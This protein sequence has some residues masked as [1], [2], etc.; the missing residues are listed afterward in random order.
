MYLAYLD[1]G[2]GSQIV[3]AIV[4][5]FAGVMVVLKLWWRRVLGLFRR[6]PVEAEAQE[7]KAQAEAP[8]STE[9]AAPVGTDREP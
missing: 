9:A 2:S 7:A 8:A 1:A 6:K 5:G 3:M 4:A